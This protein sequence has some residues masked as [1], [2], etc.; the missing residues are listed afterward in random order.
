MYRRVLLWGAFAFLL[1]INFIINY[2]NISS[3]GLIL[4]IVVEILVWWN[5]P[6]VHTIQIPKTQ[7]ALMYLGAILIE[8][9]IVILAGFIFASGYL[10]FRL[11][12]LADS[13]LTS[14]YAFNMVLIFQQLLLFALKKRA[15]S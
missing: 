4:L 7:Q 10:G 5:L 12:Y 11:E 6:S 15:Q 2:V 3:I 1:V 9:C 8:G 14:I 13:R